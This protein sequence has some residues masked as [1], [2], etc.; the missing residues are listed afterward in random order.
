MARPGRRHRPRGPLVRRGV[1]RGRP[2]ARAP[3]RGVGTRRAESARPA[4]TRLRPDPS[5]AHHSRPGRAEL[6]SG[7]PHSH[8]SSETR[9]SRAQWA[10]QKKPSPRWMRSSTSQRQSHRGW[11]HSCLFMSPPTPDSR[12]GGTGPARSRTFSTSPSTRSTWGRRDLNERQCPGAASPS[13]PPGGT[14]R[15]RPGGRHRVARE[16]AIRRQARAAA[17]VAF[18][19]T[20]DSAI[21][22]SFSFAADS[23]SSDSSRSPTASSCP[24]R[25]A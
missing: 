8:H 13:R 12:R 17:P 11:S 10:E 2:R 22:V 19:F 24:S 25:S 6:H 5:A 20:V 15:R 21:F 16:P 7:W 4:A 14:T 23:S 9:P 1:P 3:A 18:G